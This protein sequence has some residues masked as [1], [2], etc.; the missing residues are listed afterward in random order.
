[1]KVKLKE[2]PKEWRKTTLLTAL[3]LV[4]VSTLL[5]WRHILPRP[6]WTGALA[7]LGVVALTAWFWPRWYRGFYRVS[8]RVGFYSS[9]AVARW[10]LRWL[11][12]EV[13]AVA[14]IDRW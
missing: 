9:Q 11:T 8:T 7:I 12:A 6:Y 14:F 4:I 10:I 5:R 2:D 1:M 13:M 3:G